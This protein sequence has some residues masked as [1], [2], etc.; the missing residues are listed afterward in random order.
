MRSFLNKKPGRAGGFSPAVTPAGFAFI[1]IVLVLLV[2]SLSSRN[3]YEIVLSASAFV[4][5]LTV[6]FA[7]LYGARKR[8]GMEPL[9]KPNFPVTANAGEETLIAGLGP[10]PPWFFRIHFTVRGR[11]YPQGISKGCPVRA[12]TSAPRS[13]LTAPLKLRFPLG[14]IFRG[15]GSCRLRD[16]FGLFSFECG[17]RCHQ[18]FNI[19]SGSAAPKNFRLSALSGAEDRKTRSASDEERYYMREYSPGDRFRDINWKSSE[20]IDTLI[21]RISPDN[22]EKVSRIEVYFR[23][24]GPDSE[25]GV[26]LGELWLLDR[27]KARLAWFLRSVKEAETSY[28]FVIHTAQGVRELKDEAEL[29]IFLEELAGLPFSPPRNEDTIDAAGS[30][31]EIYVFS[32][33]CDAALGAFILAQSPRPLTL[34][35]A[36]FSETSFPEPRRSAGEFGSEV[37]STPSP[38]GPGRGSDIKAETLLLRDFFMQGMIPLSRWLHRR[39]ERHVR[40]G[41][42]RL[43]IDYGEVKL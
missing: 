37:S 31:G 28:V 15:E 25:S 40:A 22:Q 10:E 35:L 32:T 9:W 2:R 19:R 29:E 34:F 6:L 24:Y 38:S 4:F 3:A 43:E 39:K 27:A 30:S 20:R 41:G 36:R 11:F 1:I 23:N 5:W 17:V 33:V 7:G 12:E 8:K 16:V 14:G 18:V 21:T 26:S 42:C 13:A